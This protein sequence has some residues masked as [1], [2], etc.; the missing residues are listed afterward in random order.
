VVIWAVFVVSVLRQSS[1]LRTQIACEEELLVCI[2]TVFPGDITMI[3]LDAVR[4]R[5]NNNHGVLH[6][7][8]QYIIVCTSMY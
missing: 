6:T 5:R 4:I 7:E 1:I 3:L 8:I 2:P